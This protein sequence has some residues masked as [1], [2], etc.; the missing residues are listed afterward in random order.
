MFTFKY[1]KARGNPICNSYLPTFRRYFKLTMLM[2]LDVTCR[3][4]NK[5][6]DLGVIEANKYVKFY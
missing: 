3:K 2:N 6:D 5:I 4:Y 1:Y